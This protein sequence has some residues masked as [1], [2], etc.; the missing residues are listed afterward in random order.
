MALASSPTITQILDVRVESIDARISIIEYTTAD[1]RSTWHEGMLFLPR[2]TREFVEYKFGG[3]LLDA[4]RIRCGED[5]RK[6]TKS[7]WEV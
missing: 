7:T 5:Y 6:F 1:G 4:A 2:E 3:L